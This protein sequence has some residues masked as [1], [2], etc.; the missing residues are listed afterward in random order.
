MRQAVFLDR[1][2]VLIADTHLL[3]SPDAV[4]LLPGAV[5][6]VVNLKRAGFVVPVVTNQPVI[7]RGLATQEEIAGI[8]R[9][10]REL[11][12]REGEGETVDRFY[13][14]P[15]HPNATLPAFRMRCQCRKPA[16]GLLLKA[17]KDFDIDM[18]QSYMIGDRPS[19][20]VAGY[21][22][23]CKTILVL[24]GKH[25]EP[26]IESDAMLEGVVPD[27]VCADLATAAQ[28]IL[29][30]IHRNETGGKTIPGDKEKAL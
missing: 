10:I 23:G 25:Q 1:D 15:H 21:A 29:K 20:I 14:C 2:G 11:L 8:N 13:V 5:Q 22:A 7:A 9:Y 4:Q 24:T 26:P 17:A 30:T 6:A 12:T 19:D 18:C 27:M 28:K 3:Q 16:P